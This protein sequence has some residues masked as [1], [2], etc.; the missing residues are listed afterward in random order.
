MFKGV[1]YYTH[2]DNTSVSEQLF[3]TGLCLPSG[4]NITEEDLMGVIKCVK[5]LLKIRV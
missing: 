2:S 5:E 1:K 3:N 4:S